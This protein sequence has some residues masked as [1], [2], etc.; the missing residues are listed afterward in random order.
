M[1]T[2]AQIRSYNKITSKGIERYKGSMREKDEIAVIIGPIAKTLPPTGQ[3][4][5]R[6]GL[7]GM[8]W[9]RTYRKSRGKWVLGRY[10]RSCWTPV[11]A[12]KLYKQLK[13]VAKSVYYVPYGNMSTQ[14]DII[15]KDYDLR[16]STR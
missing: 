15:R 10:D 4:E 12:D 16:P 7:Y 5:K 3:I 14:G 6:V 8:Y 2:P 9:V 11:E 13:K 1:P